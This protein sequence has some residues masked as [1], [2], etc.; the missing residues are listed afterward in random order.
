[1]IKKR[2][3]ISIL[4]ENEPGALSRVVGIFFARGFNIESLNVAKTNIKSLS[5]ITLVSECNDEVSQQLIKQVNKVVDVFKV[6]NL[7]DSQHIERELCLIKI[8]LRGKQ[9]EVK[10]LV[11]IFGGR[12]V[13]VNQKE[14]IVELSGVNSKIESFIS[15]VKQLAKDNILEIARTGVTG[16]LVKNKEELK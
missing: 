15:A 1:M 12:V 4:L 8:D 3:I 11:D 13:S 14:F 6:Y 2:N 7:T 10:Q 16:M 5:L 9:L